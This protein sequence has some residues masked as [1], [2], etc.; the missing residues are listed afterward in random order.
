MDA[1]IR[2]GLLEAIRR[3]DV[4]EID[5]ILRKTLGP[6]YALNRLAGSREVLRDTN[7]RE[8]NQDDE[9]L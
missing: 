5:K 4:E 7:F 3:N 9:N 1:L 2:S 8:G 6:D